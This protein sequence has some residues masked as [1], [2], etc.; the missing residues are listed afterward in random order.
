M[1]HTIVGIDLG[2]Y[3]VKALQLSRV[4][5]GDEFE[6]HGYAEQPLLPQGEGAAALTLAERQIQALAALKDTGALDGDT[7][8]SALGGND[9]AMR[10]LAFPFS[11]M[12]KIELVLPSE[13]DDQ[14]PLDVDNLIL[15]WVPLPKSAEDGENPDATDVLVCFARRDVVAAHL[16]I[17]EAVDIDP[18]H[19]EFSGL[20]LDDLLQT[21]FKDR[22][23]HIAMNAPATTPGGTVIHDDENIEDAVAVL[24]IGH[25]STTF[26]IMAG[27][28]VLTSRT[29]GRGG[30]DASKALARTFGLDLAEAQSGKHK[31]AFIETLER[32]A[33][34]AEQKRIS[35]CLIKATSPIVRELRQTFRAVVSAH[36]ARVRTVILTGGGSRLT[37]LDRHLA[38]TLN[39]HVERGHDLGVQLSAVA[40]LAADHVAAGARG[41]SPESAVV[42]GLALSAL[43][44][45]RTSARV[46]FRT[47]EFAWTGSFDGLRDKVLPV[48][49]WLVVLLGVFG[50]N[51][52]VRSY[53]VGA[54]MDEI[55]RRQQKTCKLITGQ[56]I[57]SATR[58]L[59]MIQEQIGGTTQVGIPEHSA[60]DDYLEL[61]WRIPPDLSIKVSDLSITEEKLRMTATTAAFE[62]VDGVV[63]A[64]EKGRCFTNVQKGRSNKTKEGV[65][66]TVS[67]DVNCADNPGA[68]FDKAAV[69]R[70]MPKAE[71][72]P[73]TPAQAG[74]TDAKAQDKTGERDALKEK[75]RAKAKEKLEQRERDLD[76]T[77][78]KLHLGAPPSL[79][80]RR[81]KLLSSP[82]MKHRAAVKERLQKIR[83]ARGNAKAKVDAR[84]KV[85]AQQNQ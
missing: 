65:K 44:A 4:G 31:E 51:A 67:L 76:A 40:P 27:G 70:A 19:V 47:A 55:D 69:R 10:T 16:A 3:S 32:R 8:V 35:D 28:E 81:D 45:D 62:T 25:T 57:G 9:V 58:C 59:A 84:N 66:F 71:I 75:A 26:T 42:F 12:K 77:R 52:G 1:A 56:E 36:R 38:E 34:F 63:A 80:M 53:L 46:D 11:D 43:F 54:E 17:F 83:D 5:R 85:D 24:D 73:A 48:V 68:A 39:V 72:A 60:I 33:Q 64:L 14:V 18:R 7:Y 82:G 21:V 20:V 61:A 23:S 6:V 41:D 29:L 49:V 30:L 74:K 22:V 15:T 2:T 50:V 78:E 13:L 79:K 37:N